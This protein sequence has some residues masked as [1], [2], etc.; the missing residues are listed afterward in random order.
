M[1]PWTQQDNRLSLNWDDDIEV[2][3]NN[4]ND[5]ENGLLVNNDY[6]PVHAVSDAMSLDSI[7]LPAAHH[8]RLNLEAHW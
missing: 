4:Y 2:N 7:E 3:Y 5:N 6:L 1:G 8:V